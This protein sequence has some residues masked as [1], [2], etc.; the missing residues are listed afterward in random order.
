MFLADRGEVNEDMSAEERRFWE[1]EL[2]RTREAGGRSEGLEASG[3]LLRLPMILL[4]ILKTL[5][6]YPTFSRLKAQ[7]AK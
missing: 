3:V 6:P 5:C 2:A 1:P 4:A 7:Q